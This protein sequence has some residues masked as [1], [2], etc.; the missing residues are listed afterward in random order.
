MPPAPMPDAS[1]SLPTQ[2]RIVH[3]SSLVR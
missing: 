1:A 2:R 3:A